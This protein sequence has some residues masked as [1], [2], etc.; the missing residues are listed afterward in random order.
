MICQRCGQQVD[1]S[2]LTCPNCGAPTRQ[3]VNQYPQQQYQQPQR[4]QQVPSQ[5]M[6][7]QQQY[8]QQVQQQYQAPQ[9]QQQPYGQ[10]PYGQPYPQQQQMQQQNPNDSGSIGW[11][12]LGFFI[13]I[14]GLILF[15]VWFNSKP[16]NAKV[17]G[18]GALIGFILGILFNVISMMALYS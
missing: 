9:P 7:Q 15:I 18:I 2:M 8:G 11:G 10:Q 17:S 4:Q 3:P 6:P 12:I 16:N 5:Q 13:P 14:V 1:D